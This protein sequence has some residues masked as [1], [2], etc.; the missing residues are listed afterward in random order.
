MRR[1]WIDWLAD[2][3]DRAPGP[4]WLVYAGG[5]VVW[6]SAS[7]VVGWQAGVRPFPEVDRSLLVAAIF[8]FGLL[9]SLQLLD[10][11]ARRSLSE[12]RPALD[13]DAAQVA[14]VGDELERTPAVWAFMAIP[15]GLV[16]GA[17]SV[18]G[19]PTGWELN[20]GDP[21]A[22]WILTLVIACS[23]FV[24]AFG[25]VIHVIHQLRVVD[26]LHRRS[27]TIDLF[28]LEPLYAFARLTSLAG[29]VLIAIGVIG[30]GLV[31]L[32]I[33]GFE[34]APS[35]YV[36]FVFVFVVAV[37]CFIVPLLGLHGRIE[38]EK[39]RRLVEAHGSLGAALAEVRRRVAAGDFEGAARLS[40]AVAATNAGV[41][42]VSRVST[43]PW[44]PDTL[45]GFMSA[46][47]LPILLWLAITILGRLL[48]A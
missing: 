7:S 26:D 17:G 41:L 19:A 18:L 47:F 34:L 24:V 2:V 35:D 15:T 13:L 9:W 37:A 39:D 14:A 29:T 44:R 30:V 3:V 48:P 43:W 45:R 10:R 42:A 16:A 28:H 40:D 4:T 27:V 11:V 23:G 25:F 5:F 31:S 38:D 33:P 12:V 32:I 20:A 6:A 1:S 21:A 8:P 36:T 46:V 22:A